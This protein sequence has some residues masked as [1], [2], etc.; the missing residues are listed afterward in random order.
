MESRCLRARIKP[1]SVDLVKLWFSEL[2]SRKDEVL[3]TLERE[4]II[5]E[6]AFLDSIEDNYYVIYYIRSE[7]IKNALEIFK[8]SKLPIDE[9][10]K[11]NWKIHFDEVIVL[12]VLLDLDTLTR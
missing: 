11:E 12:P 2:N 5:V 8:E 1:N 4:K 9:F 6:S 3:Y 7:N 10:Y